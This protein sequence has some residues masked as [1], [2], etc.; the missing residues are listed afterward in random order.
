MS[1]APISAAEED[2]AEPVRAALARAGW[3][4]EAWTWERAMAAALAALAGG[5][6]AAARTALA[7]A[8]A[9]AETHFAADDLRRV[10]AS[11]DLAA[12]DGD[13]AALDRLAERWMAGEAWATACSRPSA[14]AVPPSTC[15]SGSAMRRG[16]SR[17][18]GAGSRRCGPRAATGWRR[19]GR[20]P[21]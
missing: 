15:G 18:A 11:A 4:V 7:G 9:L 20:G 14:R 17:S 3:P 2:I 19:C 1:A 12:L 16:S 21:A 6:A 5:H 13:T 10:T 8:A